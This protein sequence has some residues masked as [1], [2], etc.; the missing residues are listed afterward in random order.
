MGIF[1]AKTSKKREAF[2][3][4]IILTRQ[5]TVYVCMYRNINL[6]FSAD[7]ARGSYFHRPQSRHVFLCWR[8]SGGL[9]AR[10]SST[11]HSRGM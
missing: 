2:I 10:A 7:H 3:H 8:S 6:N 5:E 11:F 1:C 4:N 9:G